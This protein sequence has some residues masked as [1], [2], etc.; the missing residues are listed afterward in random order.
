MTEEPLKQAEE[1]MTVGEHQ[2]AIRI[3]EDSCATLQKLMEAYR[4]EA[5]RLRN[6][7]DAAMMVLS[8]K[9]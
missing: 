5:A 8:T 1:F 2:D 6:K 9:V 7:L 4:A 3:L